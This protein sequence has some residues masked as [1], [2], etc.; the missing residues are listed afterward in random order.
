MSSNDNVK[1]FVYSEMQIE[2]DKRINKYINRN[3][4][5][6]EV[7]TGASLK[8]YSKIINE[9]DLEG[10]MQVYPD[11]KIVYK[12]KLSET[13]YTNIDNSYIS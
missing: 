11:T 12:G 10:M 3:F 13:S 6:G 7:S 2:S 4:K 1:L 9:S 5:C 8:Q